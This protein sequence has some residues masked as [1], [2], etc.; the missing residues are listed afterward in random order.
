MKKKHASCLWLIFATIIYCV[1][2]AYLA[3]ICLY[4]SVDIFYRLLGGIDF[5]YLNLWSIDHD[6]S[7]FVVLIICV[8]G[9]ALACILFTVFYNKQRKRCLLLWGGDL[10]AVI[11]L[12]ASTLLYNIPVLK[13]VLWVLAILFFAEGIYSIYALGKTVTIRENA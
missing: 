8:I 6:E 4:E 9:T 12:F 13:Y 7:R 5:R 2:S 11:A 3:L 1:Q 10:L